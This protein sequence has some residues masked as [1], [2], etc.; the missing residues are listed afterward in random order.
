M[1]STPQIY[2]QEHN[3]NLMNAVHVVQKLTLRTDIGL[4]LKG[5]SK[6]VK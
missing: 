6:K 1:N 2:G 5:D 3:R 4:R